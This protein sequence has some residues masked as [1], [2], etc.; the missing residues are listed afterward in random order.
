MTEPRRAPRRVLLWIAIGVL[1]LMA[2]VA[3]YWA[4]AR[5]GTA[6]TPPPVT[7]SSAPPAAGTTITD[8]SAPAPTTNSAATRGSGAAGERVP[9]RP[10]PL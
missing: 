4:L 7:V 5:S 2:A 6:P 1:A 9:R 10:R 8:T 3:V